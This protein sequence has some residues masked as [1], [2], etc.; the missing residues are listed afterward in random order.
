MSKYFITFGAGNDNLIDATK[1]LTKQANSLNLF[2][3]IIS[4]TDK[5]LKDDDD[6]WQKHHNFIENN[7][8]GYG[9]WIW[10]SYL[11]NKT[12]SK[13][14][15]GD[16]LLYLDCGCEIDINK[17]DLISKNLE[18]VKD[19]LIIG[20]SS[21]CN[22]RSWTKMDL[23]LKLDVFKSYYLNS[24]QHQGG[25]VMYLI[26]DKTRTLVNEWY[27]ISCDY[28]MIDDSP[29]INQNLDCFIEHRHDQSIFSLLTKKYNL[30]SEKYSMENCIELIRNKT[31]I[32]RI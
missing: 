1:R 5:D 18:Y 27:N 2:D 3:N 25:A 21:G 17:K 14:K 26:C 31:G 23:L 13:M 24:F 6:F 11:I 8:R 9:Y 7:N 10:K 32:S 16:I 22:E 20:S 30:Y 28:H 12:I 15:D 29:S 19:D 4:Y